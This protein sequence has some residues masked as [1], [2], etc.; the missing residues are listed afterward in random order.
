MKDKKRELLNKALLLFQDEIKISQ[1]DMAIEKGVSLR[2][3]RK[4]KKDNPRSY[5]AIKDSLKFRKVMG[6]LDL[7]IKVESSDEEDSYWLYYKNKRVIGFDINVVVNLG[8]DKVEMK[9]LVN[10]DIRE[11]TIA[12]KKLRDSL[13]EKYCG[14]T[15]I[16]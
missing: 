7:R 2:A 10:K 13:I 14:N 4:I 8:L 16:L 3:I 9:N 5:K 15:V 6:E 1:K 11:T 12:D